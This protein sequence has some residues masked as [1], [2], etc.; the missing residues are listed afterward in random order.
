MKKRYAVCI[1]L[2]FFIGFPFQTAH[3]EKNFNE[4]YQY[5]SSGDYEEGVG[6]LNDWYLS[7]TAS[8][9]EPLEGHYTKLITVL[10]G[11]NLSH[12]DKL[13]ELWSFLS[14]AEYATQDSVEYIRTLNAYF[15]SL[16]AE[17]NES[18]GEAV[19]ELNKVYD[20]MIPVLQMM[21]Q[22][23]DLQAIQA[24]SISDNDLVIAS[25][26]QPGNSIPTFTEWYENHLA[27]S[28]IVLVSTVTG[29]ALIS[30]LT[31]ASWRKY[32]GEKRRKRLRNHTD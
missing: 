24:A 14:L 19:E 17:G 8:E 1:L 18:G 31:Y 2:V 5:I 22:N 13:L 4:I 6:R 10:S 16:T 28:N 32:V 30:A 27:G 9:R 3:A 21:S 7:L 26:N 20:A 15:H 25:I 11:S 29:A 12:Q 23:N